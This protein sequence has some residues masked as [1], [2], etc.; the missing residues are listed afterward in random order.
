MR[1]PVG[2]RRH[3]GTQ[4]VLASLQLSNEHARNLSWRNRLDSF[5]FRELIVMHLV[6]SSSQ[7]GML[8]I[9]QRLVLSQDGI[10]TVPVLKES[11]WQSIFQQISQ[12]NSSLATSSCHSLKETHFSYGNW[13]GW[14]GNRKPSTSFYTFIL[15][16]VPSAHM[17]G[18]V[19]RRWH[20]PLV[21]QS[22]ILHCFFTSELYFLE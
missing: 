9:P 15:K 11:K 19:S 3:P 21:P 14:D 13:E 7:L 18:R 1:K 8:F 22:S 4:V 5:H 10:T 12:G 16:P 17:W 20:R 2:H 6:T